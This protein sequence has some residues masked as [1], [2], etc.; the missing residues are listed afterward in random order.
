VQV[1]LCTSCACLRVML[2]HSIYAVRLTGLSARAGLANESR[3]PSATPI[4]GH[5]FSFESRKLDIK[6]VRRLIYEEILEFHPLEKDR[7]HELRA[8]EARAAEF[9]RQQTAGMPMPAY[10]YNH[11]VRRCSA[12]A[13]AC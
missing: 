5:A 2:Q 6:D 7:Y 8:Q 10:D 13:A 1:L 4:S 11:L 12:D 9:H 3:E